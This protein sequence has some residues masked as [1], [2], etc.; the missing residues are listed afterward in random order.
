MVQELRILALIPPT[1]ALLVILWFDH[2]DAAI[3]P[4]A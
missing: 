3:R 4:Q 1:E 2:G